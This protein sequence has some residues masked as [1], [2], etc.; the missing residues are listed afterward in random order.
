[1]PRSISR[2][3]AAKILHQITDYTQFEIDQFVRER[4]EQNKYSQC[5]I[6]GALNNFISFMDLFNFLND[7]GFFSSLGKGKGKEAR[8]IGV[9]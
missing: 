7:F 8:I 5:E 2:F 4:V 6:D 1:M 3:F 9:T